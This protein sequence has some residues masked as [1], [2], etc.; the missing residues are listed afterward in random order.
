MQHKI[1]PESDL[2]RLFT[3]PTCS[4]SFLLCVLAFVPLARADSDPFR[5]LVA[6][7]AQAPSPQVAAVRAQESLQAIVS[8]PA[9]AP[10]VATFLENPNT[11]ENTKTLLAFAARHILDGD[12][13]LVSSLLSVASDP[14][15]SPSLRA[16][17]IGSLAF[18]PVDVSFV[19]D[20]LLRLSHSFDPTVRRRTIYTLSRLGIT[21][22]Y[23]VL[24]SE[25]TDSGVLVALLATLPDCPDIPAGSIDAARAV[26]SSGEDATVRAAAADSLAQL[27]DLE[28]IPII[29]RIYDTTPPYAQI[30]L[31][32]ALR[33]LHR[34][35]Q[36]YSPSPS[37][38]LDAVLPPVP[39][40]S[41][42]LGDL[43]PG[44][45]IFNDYELLRVNVGHSGLYIGYVGPG[46]N[47][48]DPRNHKVI[49]MGGYGVGI[50]ESSMH[51]FV[52]D[53]DPRGEDYIGAG[54]L[55]R[56]SEPVRQ[57]IVDTAEQQVRDGAEYE[58]FVFYKNPK[59]DPFFPGVTFRCDGLVEYCY[60]IGLSE[61]WVPGLLNLG[62]VPADSLPTLPFPFWPGVPLWPYLQHQ[63][64]DYHRSYI[65]D[66]TPPCIHYYRHTSAP[67][68]YIYV[69]FDGD[70]YEP[71][72]GNQTILVEGS[73]SGR[74]V[75]DFEY[76]APDFEVKIDPVVDF[77][78]G[79]EV[80][81]TVGTG[82]KDRAGNGL[83]DPYVFRFKIRE[84]PP[85]PPRSIVVE[86]NVLSP[87]PAQPKAPVRVARNPRYATGVP[88]PTATAKI[89]VD[90][91]VWTGIVDNGSFDR[92]I[93]AP[94][95]PGNYL[96]EVFVS[97]GNVDGRDTATLR[98]QREPGGGECYRLTGEGVVYDFDPDPPE[99]NVVKW[100]KQRFRTT[101]D[102]VN[103]LLWLEN[104]RCPIKYV[105]RFYYPDGRQYGRDL[106]MFLDNPDPEYCYWATWGF[107][108][109]N[110][111]MSYV[112]GRY[113]LKI[114]I[115]S[116]EGEKLVVDEW[117]VLG[118]EVA[119]GLLC[120]HV[121]PHYPYDPEGIRDVFYQDDE[122]MYTWT[123]VE[124]VAQDT[125]L[126]CR[127]YEPD[128]SFYAEINGI[129]WPDYDIHG[130][131][132]RH[133]YYDWYKSWASI[134]IRGEPAAERCG[135]WRTHVEYENP[136]TGQ[137]L[138]LYQDTFQILERPNVLP[139]VSVE[140]YPDGPIETQPVSLRIEASDN[141]LLDRVELRWKRDGIEQPPRIWA[142]LN[143]KDHVALHDIGTFSGGER[144]EFWGVAVDTSGNVREAEHQSVIVEP[145]R[146]TQPDQP[147]GP[148]A[149]Q[150]GQEGTY[151]T[152]GAESNLRNPLDYQFDWGDNT[153]TPWLQV[154]SARKAWTDEGHYYVR[155]VARSRPQPHRVSPESPGLLVSVDST[156][157]MVTITTNGGEN[158]ETCKA[159]L[160]LEGTAHDDEPSSGIESVTINTGDKNEGTVWDWQFTVELQQGPNE[161][162]ISAKDNAGNV[163]DARITVTLVNKGGA[164]VFVDADAN[165]ENNGKSW[166]DAFNDLQEAL[167]FVQS[168][169]SCSNEIWVAEGTYTPAPRDGDREAIFRLI[170]GVGIYGGFN[171][172]ETRR[173][174][175]DPEAHP[176]I[177][178]GDLNGDDDPQ[179]FPGG[180]SFSENSYRVTTGSGTDETAI[181]DGFTITAGNANGPDPYDRGSGIHC[182]MGG[183][184]IVSC[185]V[186]YNT[187]NS[188]A[189]IYLNYSSPTIIDC[190]VTHNVG[191]FTAGINCGRDSSPQITNCTITDNTT[192]ASGS[193]I[194][195]AYNG[196]APTIANCTIT[197]N[198]AGYGGGGIAC[199]R[200]A[201]PTIAN[202][203]ISGNMAHK[204][205]GGISCYD[206][207]SSPRITGCTI[208]ENT[209]VDSGGG[210]SCRNG[211]D[212]LIT[213]CAITN[214]TADGGGV[215]CVLS[216]PRINN[217]I[218]TGN[219]APNLGGGLGFWAGST[220]VVS[221]C[222]IAVNT[223]AND[224][225]GVYCY[226]SNPTVNNC[227]I[228]ENTAVDSGGGLACRHNGNPEVTNCVVWG[229]APE[230]I[231]VVTSHPLIAYTDVKGGWPGVGNINAD[232]RFVDPENG[233]YRLN[234]GSRCIDAADNDAVPD[235]IET[236]LD[237]NPRFVDDPCTEDTGNGTPPI[238]DMGAYEFQ[239]I[240][241][242]P[243]NDRCENAIGPLEVP[244]T[245]EGTTLCATIDEGLP[246]CRTSIEGPGVWYYAVGTG[247][248]F[249]VD[250][251]GGA[252]F[253]TKITV[254]H[255]GCGSPVCEFGNDDYKKKCGD[256]SAVVWQS[257]PG[258]EYLILVHGA[259]GESGDFELS[260]SSVELDCD[261]VKRFKKPQCL[262]DLSI[263]TRLKSELPPGTT[264]TLTLDG[265]RPKK[266]RIGAGGVAVVMWKD[267]GKGRHEV[268]LE[269]CPDVKCRR[270]KRCQE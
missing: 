4:L 28:A 22:D 90:N 62:I 82:V 78:Y 147:D 110:N 69:G 1:Q 192:E 101:D 251:C 267:A 89:A 18:P 74:H 146:V 38:D 55:N 73:S 230:D 259:D 262:P 7:C 13:P 231:Y 63:S 118:W 113:R 32:N 68:T 46:E 11:D 115:D 179:E 47:I 188:G 140:I 246:T 161:L 10:R 139:D 213:N 238:V 242:V 34:H 29:E 37:F 254:F 96:V 168:P 149:R 193:G 56:V 21:L 195:C 105:W 185:T 184:T 128:G 142:N 127:F 229:N 198:T 182:W 252:T 258:V 58:F 210:I 137:W 255:E 245:T 172:T 170:D 228:T 202:C 256:R 72:F 39:V 156:T 108:I 200:G 205:G 71:S 134:G 138:T 218:I 41:G 131:P 234:S 201:S 248:D 241:G 268:C 36:E 80:A 60:E 235:G 14:A 99:C 61:P 97:D 23:A 215:A 233:D 94:P 226:D 240:N 232:P 189:G 132:G 221:N 122:R 171:G 220:A 199:S 186:T 45:A 155:A 209:A 135:L 100:S 75:C 166:Q 264:V 249:M 164:P 112:L 44:D 151:T 175:R 216:N 222:K 35:A 211:A 3:Q 59:G 194:G 49:E 40:L 52:T 93:S 214:N 150:A 106:E 133:D 26:L 153:K 247:E 204:W 87:N 212:P 15:E 116:R 152:G 84:D 79:E 181:L 102:Y 165:G 225:G 196:S 54:S 120:R 91:R 124:N 261:L 2:L 263:K 136:A 224:G 67:H 177:L 64:L 145:E 183:P 130:P 217:C 159:Q 169:N 5:D 237:G 167:E 157:P 117:Y 223:A 86:I 208:T 43:Q 244:S 6:I 103:G 239:D 92:T 48:N 111:A 180:P 57:R 190:T 144:I 50:K 176:T 27:R 207:G 77:R 51:D 206:E 53:G 236:D 154:P 104:V 123:K 143:T 76:R 42:G 270:S 250:T 162:V 70:M 163:G 109:R 125:K 126:R 141:T 30:S 178:S 253:D 265:A 174:Q 158:F 31:R 65:P 173:D 81:V 191:F 257:N 25:E 269:E 98:V 24:L 66:L 8:D 243:E 20:T 85:P 88:V 148:T 227:T 83:E 121:D 260:T 17:C 203:T 119:E 129:E 197:D 114:F 160:I 187:A 16:V 95:S 12:G 33:E 107:L 219:T 19:S 266:R 9:N